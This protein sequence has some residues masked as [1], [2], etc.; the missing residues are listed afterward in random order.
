MSFLTRGM[1]AVVLSMVVVAVLAGITPGAVA[2]KYLGS[3]QGEISDTTGAKIPGVSVTAEDV[4]THFKTTVTSGGDGAFVLSGLNPSTYVVTATAINFKEATRTGIVLTAGALQVINISLTAGGGAETIEV[5]SESN[6]LIDTG[7]ANIATTLSQ[8]EVTDLPNV[9]RNPFV[10]ASLGVGIST[11]EYFTVKASQ[12][13]NPYSGVAVQLSSLGSAGHNRLTLNGIPDDPAERLSGASYTGFVPSPEAVQEVKVQ[14]SIFDAQ[15]GHGNGT[16]T[17]TV[18]RGGANDFHGA[19]YYIFQNT[20]LDANNYERV[21]NQDGAL[22]PAAPTHRNNNQVA[23][24]GFVVDGPVWIPKV[25]NGRNKSFFMLSY[26]FYQTH[27]ALNFSSRVPTVAERTG[28]F[29]GLCSVFTAAGLCTNGIQIYDPNSPVVGNVRTTFFPNNRIP[30]SRINA[31]GAALLGYYPQPNIA[32]ALAT[33]ATNYTSNQTSYHSSYPSIIGRYDQAFGPKNRLSATLFRSGLTQAYPFEGFAG[34]IGP[35]LSSSSSGA[36]LGGYGYSVY[37]NNRGGSLDDVHQFNSTMVL[38]S[39]LGIIWHPFGLTYPGNSNFNLGSLGVSTSNLPYLTFPGITTTT[40]N[41]AGLAPG[42]SGQ[43]STNLTGSLEE[44]LTKT[45]GRHS[46][47]FGFEGNLIHYNVQ[48]PQSGF[49]GY[50]INRTPTQQN[51][52]NSDA[53]SGDAIAGLLLGTF[54][55]VGYN[56]TPAYALKQLYTAP[57]A[58]DDWRVTSKLTVNL[59]VRWDY[60]SPFSERYN[61]QV[62]G[63]C[64]ACSNPLQSTVTGL[65]LNGGLLYTS[66]N[67]PYPYKKDLNNWQP[68]LGFAYQVT[69]TTVLRGGFGI[70]YFNTLESPTSTGFTQAT[71][72]NGTAT[73]SPLPQASASNPFPNG[74]LLPSGSSGGLAT[75]VGTSVSFYDPTHVQPNSMQYTANLQQQ[76]PGNLS[77]QIAYVGQRVKQ[78]EVSQNLNALPQQYYYNGTNAP[79]ALANQAYLNAAV[80]NPMAGKIPTN[81]TLNAATISRYLLLQPYPEFSGVTE[82]GS[83]IGSQ[84]YDSLQIQVSK[85]MKHHLSFQGSFTWNKLFNQTTFLNNFGPGSALARLQDPGATLIGNVFGTLELPR[86]EKLNYGERL[87]L[88]GWKLNTIFR[89]QNGV[90]DLR[91]EQRIPDRQP[92]DRAP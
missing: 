9:G 91:S 58:Q 2:Q 22:N 10:L 92:G 16:V 72:T 51:Y 54:N 50:T 77:L 40:D 5:T 89:A 1:R 33:A 44:I 80:P 41:Y 23:Q 55:T 37:R 28:D 78:L 67:Q 90:L 45:W 53:N 12:Y 14:T 63:F 3:I 57:F 46:V 43:V 60:E 61:K 15:V 21:P 38:D 59:G 17:N 52:I 4:S 35:Y 31:T 13:T 71:A 62:A 6:S 69:P 34:G 39:R 11:T 25:Y 26:E 18:V 30:T 64:L 83:P 29:S 70:I 32:G 47:R 76:F 24:T 82:L 49:T 8:Q 27:T 74:V 81:N 79:G 66:S 56:I 87:A 48:N 88:G 20:Y 7:S 75:G 19:A 68:R 86:F 36:S 65:T 84:R 73:S 42:A 85:P